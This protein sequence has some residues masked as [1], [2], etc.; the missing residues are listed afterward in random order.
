MLIIQWN[1]NN[2]PQALAWGYKWNGTKYGLDIINDVAKEDKKLF[3]LTHYTGG[4]GNTL[5][6][7]GF[8]ASGSVNAK[9]GNG[10]SCESPTDGVVYA[11]AYD[12]DDWKP[13]G[14]TNPRWGSGWFVSYWS[15]WVADNY[16]VGDKWE[17][18]GWGASSRELENNSVDAWYFDV[19]MNDPEISSYYR[20]MVD[21]DDCDGKNFFAGNITPVMPPP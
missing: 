1:D 8:E 21:G 10:I 18:S 13:C 17:Y 11:H 5:A 7:I 20:C 19:D 6:G 12:Y 9:I 2:T 14:G 4:M 3:Y 16:K 15:Y